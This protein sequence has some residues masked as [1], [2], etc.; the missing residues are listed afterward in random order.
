LAVSGWEHQ[1]AEG[2]KKA[3]SYPGWQAP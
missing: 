1:H 2:E 3:E